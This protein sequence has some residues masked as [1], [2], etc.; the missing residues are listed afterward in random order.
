MFE[1]GFMPPLMFAVMVVF[2]LIGSPVAFTLAAIGLMFGAIG[3]WMGQFDVSFLHALPLR[4]LETERCRD[5]LIITLRPG[6]SLDCL[7][8]SGEG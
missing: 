2:L 1:Y 8:K 5:D 7:Q 3:V 6:A 4:F